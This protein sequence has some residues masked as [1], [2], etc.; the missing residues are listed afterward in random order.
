MVTVN[1]DYFSRFG[2]INDLM[3]LEELLISHK[4]FMKDFSNKC[5][6]PFV[7]M[8]FSTEKFLKSMEKIILDESTTYKKIALVFDNKNKI[9]C[10]SVAMFWKNIKSW[11]QMF[12][13]CNS[14]NSYFDAVKNGIADSSNLIVDYAES[15]GYY[16]YDFMVANPKNHN[17]WNKM[18]YQIP[19]I[20]NRY[21]FF[22]E[23]IIP[24]NTMPEHIKYQT[25]M[26]N[27][28][29]NVDLLYRVGH[30]R[31]EYRNKNLMNP[32]EK[33]TK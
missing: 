31:N 17:R 11:R 21:E 1:P 4:N 7:D 14:K 9:N 5:V 12:I 2:D 15:K 13:I 23:A 20:S 33:S 25:M 3:Y 29:W 26:G 18:R 24:A 8:N 19:L 16:S 22:D 32:P 27:R 6:Y 28:T 30:L 10:L